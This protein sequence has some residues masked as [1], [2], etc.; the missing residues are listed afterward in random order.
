MGKI[1]K[2]GISYAGGGA[3][4]K[5]AYQTWLDLGNTGTEQDFI[6]SLG[7]GGSSL[8]VVTGSL[9]M[10]NEENPVTL[11]QTYEDIEVIVIDDGCKTCIG[12][13]S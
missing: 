4:G 7:G 5:S 6:D 3:E 2:N 11:N 10:E 1:L 12:K 9:D 8:Y 13:N